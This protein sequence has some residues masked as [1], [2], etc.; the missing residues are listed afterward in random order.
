MPG[1]EG[2]Y[3]I[4]NTGAVWSCHHQKMMRSTLHR[5]YLCILLQR[6]NKIFRKRISRL[7]YEAFIGT[8]PPGLLV[9]HI[10]RNK[11]NNEPI[12]LR[13]VTAFGNQFNRVARRTLYTGTSWAY[14][15]RIFGQLYKKSGFYSEEEA[16]V[17]CESLRHCHTTRLAYK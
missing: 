14:G 2:K 9:D 4:S 8:I 17:A 5:G 15:T 7:V 10:D 13:C 1:F 6:D 16:F 12:N 3:K 11:L